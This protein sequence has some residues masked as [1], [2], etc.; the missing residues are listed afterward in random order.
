MI[1]VTSGDSN[2]YGEELVPDKLK[3]RLLG[4]S[5]HNING[6]TLT[7]QTR[8]ETEEIEIYRNTHNWPAQL[9]KKLNAE[10]IN[11]G[12]PGSSNDYISRSIL[13]WINYNYEFVKN[14]SAQLVFIVGLTSPN[15][16]EFILGDNHWWTQFIPTSPNELVETYYKHLQN[17]NT[18]LYSTWKNIFM[19][20]QT[21]VNLK[22]K[23]VF[24]SCYQPFLSGNLDLNTIKYFTNMIETKN[25]FKAVMYEYCSGCEQAPRFH[26]LEEGHKKW[27]EY[28]Y[29]EL[30]N[31]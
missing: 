29:Q 13:E 16:T 18:D 20:Q 4:L 6:S 9:G 17:N 5:Q 19:L 31:V 7:N 24:F 22:I 28:L 27:A 23:H 10:V 21:F 12:L 1:L 11:L 30:Q 8:L 15:R 14:N 25:L 26:F 2:T 3:S